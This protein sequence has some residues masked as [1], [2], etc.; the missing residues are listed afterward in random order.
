MKILGIDTSTLCG[1]MALIE[2]QVLRA[3][4][5][6]NLGRKHTERLLPGLEW[7]FTELGIE[8]KELG[9]IVVGIGPG[10]F[11][12]LRVGLSTAKGLALS[13]GIPILG[14]S[15]LKTLAYA[16]R[17]YPGTILAVLDARKSQVFAQFFTGGEELTSPG[18]PMVIEPEILVKQIPE[19]T[20]LVGEGVRAYQ[21][22]FDSL[23]AKVRFSGYEFDYPKASMLVQLG[24]ERLNR[25][26]KDSLDELVPIYLRSSDAE[27][28]NQEAR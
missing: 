12:G 4:I 24:I 17:F 16:V 19:K 15:S 13:L 27:L 2:E 14:I 9:A 21:D 25:G 23:K 1:S 26:E 8:P 11:T 18:E 20:L 5:N 10:S 28:K 3:E 6:V 7:I 22:L